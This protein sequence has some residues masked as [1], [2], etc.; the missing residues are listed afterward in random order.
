MNLFNVIFQTFQVIGYFHF[1]NNLFSLALIQ[2]CSFI[3][4]FASPSTPN[5]SARAMN[6]PIWSSATSALPSC[7]ASC[8][9]NWGETE[10]QWTLFLWRRSL[11]CWIPL[12]PRDFFVEECTYYPDAN[13]TRDP[14]A[15]T[16]HQGHIWELLCAIP[17]LLW[18]CCCEVFPV[19]MELAPQWPWLLCIKL[20]FQ[21]SV[22]LSTWILREP[23]TTFR[24]REV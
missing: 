16:G 1:L 15:I 9:E 7:T 4:N 11:L 5:S 23:C 20:T 3:S 10:E 21:T 18:A 19:D 6:W 22:H 17:K 8:R 2:R 12:H 13:V 14:L 24:C